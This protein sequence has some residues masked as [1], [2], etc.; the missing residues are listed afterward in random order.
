MSRM[1][2]KFLSVALAL[3]ALG[4]WNWPDSNEPAL[5]L[6]R[7]VVAGFPLALIWFSEPLGSFMGSVGR[8]GDVTSETPGWMIAGVGWIFLI[9]LACAALWPLFAA[10][11]AD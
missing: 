5:L 2:W 6:K 9:A 1:I 10:S 4:L 7:L 11:Q 8:G 3:I